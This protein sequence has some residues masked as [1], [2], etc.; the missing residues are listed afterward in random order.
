MVCGYVK[1]LGSPRRNPGGVPAA[2]TNVALPQVW[3]ISAHLWYGCIEADFIF[4]FMPLGIFP[5]ERKKKKQC[6]ISNMRGHFLRSTP[7]SQQPCLGFSSST[8]GSFAT[9]PSSFWPTWSISSR[10]WHLYWQISLTIPVSPC[11]PLQVYSFFICNKPFSL[12]GG[13]YRSVGLSLIDIA[14]SSTHRR[15]Q[16]V[17]TSISE[18]HYHFPCSIIY[19]QAV[20]LNY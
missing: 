4:V 13:S 16:T 14:G 7:D 6:K 19:S 3:F 1:G 10:N 20:Y 18:S 11:Y 9:E 12:S 15:T 2:V 17:S 8:P 5:G